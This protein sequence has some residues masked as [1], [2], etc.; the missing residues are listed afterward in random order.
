MRS[1]NVCNL[2]LALVVCVG[3]AGLAPAQQNDNPY[4][5]AKVGDWISY[6]I[7][8]GGLGQEM[9]LKQTVAAKDDTHATVKLELKAGNQ[10]LPVQMQKIS[11]NEAFDPA[12]MSL[13]G[14][15][16]AQVNIKKIDEGKETIEIGPKKYEC[17]WVK[18]QV[19]LDVMGQTMESISKI[20]T[21]KDLPFGGML[22]VEN[23]IN[24]RKISVL[25]TGHGSEK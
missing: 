22:K 1:H 10:P 20:W 21:T 23:E 16:Q 6:K 12:R 9:T 15:G 3:F 25:Y 18:N 7:V 5:A 8:T 14:M 4:V 2:G 11:L 24:N 17:S 13:F 19:S